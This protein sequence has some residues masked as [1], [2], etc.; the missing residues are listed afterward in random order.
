MVNHYIRSGAGGS[1]NG[2]DWMNAL[3]DIPFEM[4]RGDT[5]YIADGTYGGYTFS[6]PTSGSILITIRKA[7]ISD[8]GTNTGWNNSYGDG[9]AIFGSSTFTT[10]YW[11]VDGVQGGGPGSWDIG[12]G[13]KFQSS[14]HVVD[15]SYRSNITFSHVEF[16][17]AG[18]NS[19]GGN[20]HLI[21]GTWGPSYITISYSYLHDV[22][23]CQIL[24]RNASY[25]TLEY[26]KLAR[27]GPNNLL[28]KEAWSGSAC[29]NLT[30]RYN[31]FEDISNTAF[32][33][34]VNGSGNTNNV[35]IYGNVFW[36]TGLYSDA[37]VSKLIDV[38]SSE[39][40]YATNWKIYNNAIVNISNPSNTANICIWFDS[41]SSSGNQCKNNIYFN[42]SVT[43]LW[44][45]N[46]DSAYNWYY[47]NWRRDVTPN[48][49]LDNP[50]EVHGQVG[51]QNPFVNW[52]AGNFNL[53]APTDSGISLPPPYNQ[54]MNGITRIMWSRGAFE[55]VG[56]G[57]QYSIIGSGG[58]VLGGSGVFIVGPQI[59]MVSG[60][61]IGGQ[62]AIEVTAIPPLIGG[63]VL[64]GAGSITAVPLPPG[65]PSGAELLTPGYW[66]PTSWPPGFWA[67]DYWPENAFLIRTITMVGGFVLGGAGVVVAGP[68]LSVIGGI[69]IGGHAAIEIV[70]DFPGDIP[71][72]PPGYWQKLYWPPGF[73][74]TDYWLKFSENEQFFLMIGGAILGGP[75]SAE[76]MTVYLPTGGFLSGGIAPQIAAPLGP[77]YNLP[78]TGVEIFADF[79]GGGTPET[80]GIFPASGEGPEVWLVKAGLLFVI[81]PSG[82]SV[83]VNANWG[84][85]DSLSPLVASD[86]EGYV[87]FNSGGIAEPWR[88]FEE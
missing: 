29:S 69:T 86:P 26:S 41:S 44:K 59:S 70:G 71:F 58:P 52:T 60:V 24:T 27:N 65:G 21:Y 82:D 45:K 83:I 78:P 63:F 17:G 73:W 5:Y 84:N 79:S 13:F 1:N 87:E 2:S 25:W 32:I 55:Y 51:T 80:W 38:G 15:V 64:G 16:K 85:F 33:G 74:S 46:C 66:Q 47:N 61:T 23:G 40:L 19:G 9:Q 34:F 11:V 10:N 50:G 30:I 22:A 3:P 36:Y 43:S 68:E 88:T 42:N 7:T 57:Q 37:S 81:T 48:I 72:L 56:V 53:T 62:P 77:Y 4:T 8:H 35:A 75:A 28:H 39:G 76:I 20:D 18:R 14:G 54:D 49:N 6:T 67:A 12:H 31:I